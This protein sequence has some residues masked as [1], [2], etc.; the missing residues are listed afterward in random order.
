MKDK[1]YN[2][3]RKKA[4]QILEQKRLTMPSFYSADAEKVMHDLT[5]HQ[6]ELELQNEELRQTQIE[7]EKSRNKYSALFELAPVGYFTMDK[8]TKIREANLTGCRQFEL[9]RSQIIGQPFSHFVAPDA[10]DLFYFH[11]RK[12]LESSKRVSDE[13]KLRRSTGVFFY[14]LIESLAIEDP[15]NGK[16]VIRF[17]IS[18]ISELKNAQ[19]EREKLIGELKTALDKV[20]LLSGFIP[21]CCT[22]K[23]IRDDKGY[24]NQLETYIH[25]HSEAEFSHGICPE[26]AKKLYPG[27]YD[28]I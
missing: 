4:E 21:I 1:K 15:E 11:M 28:K 19:E 5:V 9:D 3:L 24:W 7:L 23:K 25:D 8:N 26:C 27:Y 2:E 17:V 10:Q 20:K 18:D 14:A 13:I 12:V 6:I 16:S 22:C